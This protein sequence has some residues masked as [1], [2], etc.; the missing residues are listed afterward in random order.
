MSAM[1]HAS[2][3][4]LVLRGGSVLVLDERG[5][6]AQAVAV[7]GGAIVAV[8][9]DA[10]IEPWIGD[11]TRVIDL[12]GRAVLPGIN[13][14]HLHA[15]WMGARYPHTLFGEMVPGAEPGPTGA[16]VSSRADRRAALLRAGKL[17]AAMGITS[18]TEPG[19]GPGEDD[20]ET[21]CFHSEV[22]DVYRELAA[23][24]ELQQRVTLLTLHGILDGPSSVGAVVDGIRGQEALARGVVVGSDGSSVLGEAPDPRWLA[25]PG[26]KLFGD[27][28]P[29]SRNAWTARTYDDGS[30]GGLLVEGETLEAQAAGLAEMIAEAHRAGVQV[31]VHATGDRTIELVLDTVERVAAEPGTP[32]AADLAHVIV[33][34]D[35]ATVDQVQRMAR[36]GMFVNAQAGI[37]AITGD[38]LVR[39]MGEEAAVSA[40]PFEAAL[41]AGVLALSSDAPVLDFDWRVGIANA[42]ARILKARAG[43]T[44][45]ELFAASLASGAVTKLDGGGAG[46][47]AGVGAGAG[48][49]DSDQRLLGLLRAYTAVPARQDRA[50]DWKGTVEVGK[51]ADLVVLAGDP[52]EVGAAGLPGLDVELTVVDGSVVFER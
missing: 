43:G 48:R 24:G 20:G 44:G 35:L 30:H 29:L 37:A 27:L 47:G 6:R 5:S 14:S 39:L 18:Y 17:L 1:V 34:G 16:L 7:Q 26:V 23:A 28:I 13:D 42:D 36:L 9:T 25:V 31:G 22:L 50:A 11:S 4:D 3:A 51:V 10:D 19:I 52:F 38:W 2:S 21:G 8:G 46:A 41:A 33:H 32:A 49:D 40:W 45:G 12:A 15:S